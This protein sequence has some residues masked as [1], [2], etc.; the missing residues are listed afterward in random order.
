MS[1]INFFSMLFEGVDEFLRE[2]NYVAPL[3]LMLG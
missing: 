1:S 3:K 2:I